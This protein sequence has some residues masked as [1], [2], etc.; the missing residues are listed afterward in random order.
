MFC[1][2]EYAEYFSVVK[3]DY[4]ERH[5]VTVT[6]LRKRRIRTSC[7]GCGD[8]DDAEANVICKKLCCVE[9]FASSNPLVISAVC[10]CFFAE[11]GI[12]F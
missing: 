9:C 1:G 10:F 6:T 5:I 11:C 7:G 2:P 3:G 12:L 8:G 4:R